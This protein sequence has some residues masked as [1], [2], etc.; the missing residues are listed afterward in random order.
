MLCY[1]C[2]CDTG[3]E[4]GFVCLMPLLK[5]LEFSD[6]D[7]T[8]QNHAFQQVASSGM[9]AKNVDPEPATQHALQQDSDWNK[10]LQC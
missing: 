6:V 4:V 8:L 5:S 10:R 2:D 1:L 7:H 3:L 9:E